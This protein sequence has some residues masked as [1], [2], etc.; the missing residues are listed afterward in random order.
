MGKTIRVEDETYEDLEKLII[1]R[2]TFNNVIQ[3]LLKV[4]HTLSEVSVILG[5]EHWLKSEK[6]PAA[7]ALAKKEAG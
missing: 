6:S 4:Y 5:P 1:H 7:A 2:E 3:R